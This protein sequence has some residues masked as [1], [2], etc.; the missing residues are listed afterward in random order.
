MKG[1]IRIG[2]HVPAKDDGGY[3]MTSW[4]HVDCFKLPKKFA[5]GASAMSVEE[6]FQDMVTDNSD[7]NEIL[8]ARMDEL[9]AK[10]TAA[11]AAKTPKKAAK[12][13]DADDDNTLV[14]RLKQAYIAEQSGDEKPAKKLKRDD[15]GEFDQLLELYKEHHKKKVDNL[16]DYLR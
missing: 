3:D 9:V 5:A 4:H 13:K 15:D 14:G 12:K 6:F 16:K 11:S 1:D 10:V 2:V 8:P 7:D